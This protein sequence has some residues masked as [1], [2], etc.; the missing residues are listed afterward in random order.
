MLNIIAQFKIPPQPAT[1][2]LS[3]VLVHNPDESPDNP[4]VAYHWNEDGGY[5]FW[6]RYCETEIDGRDALQEK[7][8]DYMK[9][10]GRHYPGEWVKQ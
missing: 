1:A 10:P 7:V 3:L 2:S 9:G 4:W 8:D 6:G 5:Y